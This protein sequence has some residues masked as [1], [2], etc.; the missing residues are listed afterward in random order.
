MLCTHCRVLARLARA[1]WGVKG[2]ACLGVRHAEILFGPQAQIDRDVTLQTV[3][4]ACIAH[5]SKDRGGSA[6]PRT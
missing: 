5:R 2:A 6:A 3:I 1:E 4:G